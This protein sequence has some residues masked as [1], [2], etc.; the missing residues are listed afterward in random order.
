MTGVWRIGTEVT[1]SR[2]TGLLSFGARHLPASE[3]IG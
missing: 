2:T 1:V 3:P